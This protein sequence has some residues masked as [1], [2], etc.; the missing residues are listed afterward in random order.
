M[1]YRK[2]IDGLRAVAVLPVMLF[3]AGVSGFSGGFVGV[4]VFFVISG[5]LITTILLE[6]R[7]DGRFSLLGFYDRRIRR[8]LPAL[9]FVMFCSIPA[10]WYLMLPDDLENFGQSLVS[11]TLFSNNILLWITSDYFQLEAE[12]KPLLHTWSLAVEEQYYI[13]FPALLAL[14]WR[15]GRRHLFAA[16][17][18][19]AIASLAAAEM[20]SRFWPQA[21]FYLIPFRAWEL[22]AGALVAIHFLKHPGKTFANGPL[23]LAGLVLIL[24]SVVLYDSGTPFPGVYALVPVLGTVLFIVYGS[25][26]TLAARVLSL[27]P[28]VLVGLMSYSLYLWHQPMLAFMRIS[29]LAEPGALKVAAFLASSCVLGWFSWR[30]VEA[31]FRNRKRIGRIP[32]FA[33]AAVSSVVLLSVGLYLHASSGM[34]SRWPELMD[35]NGN[36]QIGSGLN[37][38]YN[39]GP[40]ALQADV[41]ASDAAVKVLVMGDSFGRDF[42]NA[43]R[44]NDYFSR[45]DV[46][47]RYG[48]GLCAFQTSLSGVLENL[49][50]EAD[51][52]VLAATLHVDD[53]GCVPAAADYL[54]E[55][56]KTAIVFGAKNFGWNNNAIMLLPERRRYQ[57]RAMPLARVRA[58][59]DVVGSAAAE[60]PALEFVNPMAVLADSEGRVP[61]FTPRKQFISQDRTHFTRAGAQWVGRM[62]LAHPAV[63]AL[64]ADAGSVDLVTVPAG[65]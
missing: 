35:D 49:I 2:E 19:V 33:S 24:A 6:E 46:V 50:R 62:L 4:D 27:R 65:E 60:Y 28:M 41:F 40:Y 18:L 1:Q 34:I 20:A 14:L 59:N 23:A 55:Q 44:E 15:Y 17:A 48:P 45:A 9:Y 37:A 13:V 3:H 43:G 26:G 7:A 47:Y 51:H 25:T 53:A 52:I 12:F 32:L 64:A 63:Q 8:I 21:A 11:T 39:E 22:M 5:Y 29:S 16:L 42:I 31:P 56:G 61:V 58:A 38:A 36:N 54:A 57:Y 30:Y 10:A